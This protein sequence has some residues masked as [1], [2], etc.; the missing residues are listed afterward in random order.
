[1]KPTEVLLIM[2]SRDISTIARKHVQSLP[3]S[4]RVLLRSM[5]ALNAGGSDLMSYLMFESSFTRE[6]ID[7]G[8]QDALAQRSKIIDFIQGKD[9]AIAT[10][11]A[12]LLY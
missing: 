6:L 11:A 12:T 8:Y 4:L 3:R 9:Q 10:D 1:M 2:P 7:L 5:G